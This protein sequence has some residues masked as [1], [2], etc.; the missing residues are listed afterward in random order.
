MPPRPHVEEPAWPRTEGA[1]PPRVVFLLDASSALERRLLGDWILRHRPPGVDPAS[2]EAVSIP[3]SRRGRRRALDPRLEAAL[4]DPRDALLAPLRVIWRPPLIDGVR[5]VR[6]RHLLTFGDPRDPSTLRQHWLI[7]RRPERCWIVAGEPARVSE[8]R[9]RWRKATEGD[10]TATQGL[11]EF[12]AH[13]AQLSLE[14]AERR[15][16][17]QQYK[18]PR[19]VHHDVLGRVAFRGGVARLARELGRS[20]E[21]VLREA[22]RN[23]REIAATHSAYVIDLAARLIRLLYTRGYSETLHYDREQLRQLYA[24]AQRYPVVFLPSHKSNLDHLVLQYALFENGL[25][26]NHTA[27][28]INMNFFPVGPLVRRSGVFFIRRTFKDQPI[29]KFVLRSYVDYLIEKRFSLEW[30]V[31]G[32]RSR[33][34][35]LLPP[36]MGLMT[37]VVDS[38]RRGKSEDVYLLPVSIAYDQI[39]DVGDYAAEQRGARK[40]RESFRWFL[41][42]LRRLRGRY[43]AI[44]LRFGEPLSLARALG[45]GPGVEETREEESLEVQK[46]AFEVCVR[47][48][49]A[50]PITPTSLVTLALLGRGDRALDT[51]TVVESLRNLL[52]YVE[53]RKLPTTSDLQL[54]TTQCVRSVLEELVASGVVTCYAEGPEAVFAIGADQHLAAAYYRNTIIHFFVNGAIAELA[55]LRAVEGDPEDRAAEFWNAAMRLRDLLKFEFFFAE[56]EAFRDELRQEIAVHDGEWEWRLGNGATEALALLRKFRPFL[57]HRVLRPFVEAYRVVADTLERR[58]YDAPFEAGAFFGECQARGKQ[59]LLQRRSRSAESVSRVLYETGLKL[60]RNQRLVEAD[61]PELAERRAAF[62]AE[63][64]ELL[65]RIDAIDAMAAARIAGL[66]Q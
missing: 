60:A 37:Y 52:Y 48:N 34:G 17:G 18:V 55:L 35:K 56:K 8:L 63:I 59:Y 64:R 33:S 38:F 61:G 53:Q 39:T 9:E 12:V 46:L 47:I 50:T 32:G 4:A 54:D 66:V 28:G 25:P 13:Q 36:R 31:E 5:A 19:L 22:A 51:E 3:P 20:E 27:G 11:A 15:L 44:H 24:L 7:R 40:E 45:H 2:E 10:Q 57:A 43:G 21:S 58:P 42:I 65:R 29:Y 49:R 1:T 62:A 30:Y 16:R 41:R 6:L 14:R 26:P 23:L